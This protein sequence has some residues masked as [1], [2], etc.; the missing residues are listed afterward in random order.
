M[1]AGLTILRA[2][3]VAGRP[4]PM[5]KIGSFEQWNVVREAL[6]WLECADPEKTRSAIM[7]SDPRKAAWSELL[8]AWYE[9][10]IF[11]GTCNLTD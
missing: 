6:V 11:R 1:A 9:C 5:P 4:N 10:Q 3:I 2:Y 8:D 7:A